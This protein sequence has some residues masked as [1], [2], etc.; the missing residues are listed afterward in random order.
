MLSLLQ[1]RLLAYF[2]ASSRQ[3]T[4]L[5]RRCLHVRAYAASSLAAL[6]FSVTICAKL[7]L[8]MAPLAL[9]PSA[10][11]TLSKQRK[12]L[13]AHLRFCQPG[14]QRT[15]LI[16]EKK[17]KRTL[18]RLRSSV[19]KNGSTRG[20]RTPSAA[21]SQVALSKRAQICSQKGF[22]LKTKKQECI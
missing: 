10:S 4:I 6:C 14:S 8:Q 12:R 11:G 21:D 1:R 2:V 13:L 22:P 15:T 18:R 20:G 16:S 17:R 5:L 19:L 3:P 7:A 9:N